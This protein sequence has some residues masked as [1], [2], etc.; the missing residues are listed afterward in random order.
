MG[1]KAFQQ[2][3]GFLR[4]MN[5]DN[6]LD[7]S[8]VHPEAYPLVQKIISDKK[9]SIKEIIGNREL[10][11]SINAEQYVDENFG[12]PTIRDVLRELEKPGRDPRPEFRTAQF[13]EGVEDIKD[14]EQGMVLEGV[15]SNVTNF[16]AFV[17][18]GVHQDGLV[19]ISA[20]TNRFITDPRSVV[21]AG[22]IV[23]VKVVEVDK[24]RR[25]IGLSMKLNDEQAPAVLQKANKPQPAK[26]QAE[27]KQPEF[28]KKQEHKKN[29]IR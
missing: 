5:G 6:A 4:I 3:A 13:K 21:K 26:K 23:K 28:K 1:E 24:E 10:L 19:H 2:A 8:C 9:V 15:V 18:I 16:G 11:Q 20:M 29:Q 7:A 17:D 27:Q 22:D 25:R 14:L 12:L